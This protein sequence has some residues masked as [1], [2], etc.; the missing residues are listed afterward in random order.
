MRK[1]S[2]ALL[3]YQH[4]FRTSASQQDT[5][6]ERCARE[7]DACNL[8]SV[9]LP[10]GLLPRIDRS[11][12]AFDAA[13]VKLAHRQPSEHQHAYNLSQRAAARSMSTIIMLDSQRCRHRRTHSTKVGSRRVRLRSTLR[14][15]VL[16]AA[17]IRFVD[18]ISLQHAA[19][20][21]SQRQDLW[22]EG[23]LSPRDRRQITRAGQG[24]LRF[25]NHR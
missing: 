6:A 23:S 24:Q 5:T 19:D 7:R 16:A 22:A 25:Q 11:T 13:P 17:S 9:V 8:E 1:L 3:P 4:H 12:R 20:E 21:S 14:P 18:S 10:R 15:I 2:N